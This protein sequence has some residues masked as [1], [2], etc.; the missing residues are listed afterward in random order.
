MAPMPEASATPASPPASSANAAPSARLVGFDDAR[1]GVSGAWVAD[2]V[3]EL[4]GIVRGECRRLVDRNARGPLV[5]GR[6]L[7]G[8]TDRAGRE[9][10]VGAFA[11]RRML[12]R[13]ACGLVDAAWARCGRHS[14]PHI[15]G[16]VVR[17]VLRAVVRRTRPVDAGSCG[18]GHQS[19]GMKPPNVPC[20]RHVVIWHI[21]ARHRSRPAVVSPRLTHLADERTFDANRG[22]PWTS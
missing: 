21:P 15:R 8:G 7:R 14:M 16:P 9:A 3:A 1:V 6:R 17:H 11:H 13:E 22:I 5:H 19:V 4:L 20:I 18:P 10:L 2:D 12:H